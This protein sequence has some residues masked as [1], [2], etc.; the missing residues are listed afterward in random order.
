MQL[1]AILFDLDGTLLENDMDAFITAFLRR[2]MPHVAHRVA[3][4]TFVQAWMSATQMMLRNNDPSL[5]NQ[6]VFDLGFYPHV[7]A[8]RDELWP[9]IQA[10]YATSYHGLRG[11]TKPRP[12]ARETIQAMLDAGLDVVIA[13]NP[14]FPATAVQQRLD[15]ADVG[16]LPYALV[17]SSENMHAAKPNLH[18]Y[19]QIL[20]AIG[21][22]PGEC[23]MV[24][25]DFVNDVQ[26]C[27][28]LGLRTYWVNIST[29]TP[30]NFDPGARGQ[31]HQF[32]NWLVQTGLLDDRL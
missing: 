8:L 23:L 31:L 24:G 19:R 22:A 7:G 1:R 14:I 3:P 10:F 32:Y 28:R 2:L 4:E 15:W 11:L 17:T 16:D 9:S 18:Y 21:R 25:D 20:D 5:T 30:P 26:P 6:D 27:A 12:G 29:T 13:T